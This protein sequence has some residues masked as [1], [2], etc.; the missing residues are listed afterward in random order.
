MISG[1]AMI[2]KL[3][4]FLF[5]V[6]LV[7]SSQAQLSITNAGIPYFEN[8][9][10][11][12]NSGT[13]SVLPIGWFMSTATYAADNGSS[14]S[15][16][17]Y[18]YGTTGSTERAL[19]SL[20]TNSTQPKFG[21]NFINNSG[22]TITSITVSYTGE[23]WRMGQAGVIDRLDF[24]YSLTAT[25]VSTGTWID[26]NNLDFTPPI[27][28]GSVGPLDGNN[29]ANKTYK[30]YTIT[31][32]NIGAAAS[33][34]LRW[35]DFNPSGADHGNG[36]DDITIAFNG[37]TV[38]PC[39]EPVAQPTS[40]ILNSTST[41]VNG[42]FSPTS[43]P[44]DEYLVVRSIS[45]S[46]G[47][48]PAD[49]TTY[50]AG[51]SFGGGTI[52][53]SGSATT[54]YDA[55]LSPNTTYYYFIFS[56]NN[57]NCS[58]GPNYLNINPLTGN[59]NTSPLL[60]CSA[61]SSPPTNLNLS[62]SNTIVSGNFTAS[63]SANRYLVVRSLNSSVGAVP[64]NGVTYAAGQAFGS[65]TVV[66]YSN[67]LGF[68]SNALTPAT[69]YYFFVFAANGDCAG[70]PFYNT[71]SLNGNITT[72]NGNG[73]PAGYY[74]S[75]TGLT[76]QPL[77]TALKNII[78]PQAS[79]S[80]TP[81]VWNAYPY[82]DLHRND[83]NTADIVWDMYSDNPT[84]PE[85]YTYTI[86]TNQC[87][88]YSGEGNCYNREHSFPQSWFN[89]ALPMKSDLHH[90]F[91]TDGKVNGERS[92]FPYGEV[93]SPTW[94]SLNGG[95]LGTGNNF[96]YTSTTFEPINEYKGDLARAQLY[97]AVRYEDLI[98]GW[99]SNGNANEVLLSPTDEPDA[100]KRKL[101]VY[102]TWFLKELF[103]WHNQDPVSQKEI[104]RNNAIY[105]QSVN[106]GGVMKI[107]GNRNPFIDHP[108]YAQLI[109]QCTGVVSVTI[110]GFEGRSL[111]KSVLLRW[112][113]TYETGFK[114]YIIERSTD[115]TNYQSVGEVSGRNLA[116]YSF[117][118]LNPPYANV[119][120]YRL[121]MIDVDGLERYSTVIS[122]R[123]DGKSDMVIYP[124]P[125]HSSLS[126]KLDKPFAGSSSITISDIT[127][128][129]IFSD[130]IQSGAV[131]KNINTDKLVPGKYIL[132][133]NNSREK[134]IR[135]FIIF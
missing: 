102:D 112:Y 58:G 117:E 109:F 34:W 76:C 8:F 92:D 124:N 41:T 88:N 33:F 111:E 103:K 38:A 121:K 51:Q 32:L 13:S 87:G 7:S 39:S 57:D 119:L 10:S 35:N 64:V 37:A 72:S 29:S 50:S 77:K 130:Q 69:T 63:A 62:A 17:T 78:L 46:L 86:I 48:L 113:A 95:K 11:L 96:G 126:V 18:S 21:I 27:T 97:M 65:G 114:K 20:T 110:F 93:T 73:I 118:D 44:T 28:T 79:L 36:I 122:V 52:I 132:Q 61:P 9:N 115:G 22:V 49:G 56:S 94:T 101:Q 100:T 16:S 2:K 68:S 70:E 129:M 91:P 116:N 5:F 25:D 71:T 133:I 81:G 128:R 15:G 84:G 14:T 105:Y 108:E 30:T 24:Q 99:Y 23:Q 120:L 107:Q 26:E 12:A 54:F 123:V 85:P 134:V 19:S 80:Y 67:A 1:S 89:S 31:G 135:S 47:S 4:P 60:A 45:S 66:S 6:L 125:A 3:L 40:L 55:G 83:A 74:G 82:T 98:N 104:D 75:A 43:N 127:G 53:S 59:I 90:L 42:S 106:D 131:N